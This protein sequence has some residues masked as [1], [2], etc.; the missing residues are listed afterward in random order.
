VAGTVGAMMSVLMGCREP[1]TVARACELGMAMQ[2]TNIARD[3]GE[4]A[5]AGRL[6]LP[7]DWLAEAGIEPESWLAQPR[8][9]RPVG[10]VVARLL[11]AAD[12]LYRQAEPGI[13]ALP[14]DCR[15]GIRAARLLYAEIGAELARQDFNSI[16]VRAVV[17]ATRKAMLLARALAGGPAGKAAVAP[18]PAAHF[19]ID[20]VERAPAPM[21]D[22]VG[23][24]WWD[25]AQITGRMVELL[26]RI[27][28]RRVVAAHGAAS[29]GV[30]S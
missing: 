29:G 1:W 28:Q 27:E 12:R 23:P 4:D 16:E 18:L 11:D 30:A 7:L 15:P 17:P 6:Y 13:A 2:L 3:V 25:V 10:D 19:L 14:P 24:P 21:T 20:A 9:V 5:A 8:F 26:Q 22:P